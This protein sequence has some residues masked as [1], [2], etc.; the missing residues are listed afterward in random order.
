MLTCGGHRLTK[1][2]GSHRHTNTDTEDAVRNSLD[3][4]EMMIDDDFIDGNDGL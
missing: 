2:G 4:L 1:I 3:K